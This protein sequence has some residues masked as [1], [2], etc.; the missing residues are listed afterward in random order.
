MGRHGYPRESRRKVLELVEAGRPIAEVARALGISDQSIYTWCR[1]DRIDRGL[2]PGLTSPEKTELLATQCRIAELETELRAMRRAIELVREVVPPKAIPAG[3]P[4]REHLHRGMRI[5]LH[6]STK[7]GHSMASSE[8]E[9]VQA[10]WKSSPA[11]P[12]Q[13]SEPDHR[14]LTSIGAESGICCAAG[15]RASPRP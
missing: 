12:D 5:Q 15:R 14:R 8:P 10:A 6:H 3:W 11:P 7:P 4:N 9:A 1:Q 2:E 13:P